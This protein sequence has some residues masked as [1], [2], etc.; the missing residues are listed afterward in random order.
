M[1]RWQT[2]ASERLRQAALEL[3]TTRGFDGVTV[4]EIAAAAGLT[5]RTFFRY[6]TDKRDVLFHDQAGFE[7]TFL[8]GLAKAT[9]HDAMSLIVAALQGAT[10]FFPDER[11]AWSRTRSNVIAAH[12]A[13]RER[14]VFKMSALAETLTS[15]LRE[16]GLE[17]TTAALAAESGVTVFRTAFAAWIA[18]GEERSF[19]AI[20]QTVLDKLHALV[21]T[22]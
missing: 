22:I 7:Q 19:A 8:T 20:Q 13:L 16:R 17:A 12:L 5:E 2:G 15:A 21:S 3:F 18:D 6:F 1:A 4:A 11:R 10:E 14:E 9:D